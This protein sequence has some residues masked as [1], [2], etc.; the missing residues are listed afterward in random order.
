MEKARILVVED[1]NVVR[2]YIKGTLEALGYQI[3][4][5]VVSGEEAIIQAEK[6]HP[7]LVLM[8]IKLKG[9]LDGVDAARQIG[10][11]FDI[12]VIYLTSY[13]DDETLRRAKKTKPF[14]YL[15][16][17]FDDKELHATIEIALYNHQQD[18]EVK[19]RWLK[20]LQQTTKKIFGL[21]DGLDTPTPSFLSSVSKTIVVDTP[22][23]I[24]H[25]ES[26][27]MF[28]LKEA[29]E[30]LDISDRT[31][32]RMIAEGIFPEPSVVIDLGGNRKLRRWRQT[33]LDT[34][35]PLLRQRGRPKN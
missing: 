32:Q 22:D 34:C 8:D 14:G 3:T 31:I 15:V 17:P 28:T 18:R 35:K 5:A 24:P 1:E 20:E 23:S 6:T 13:A 30:Y 2:E 4:A 33:D 16:K 19:E 25:S 27:K 7:D 29:A 26:E 10:L 9:K 12:P 11:R 21:A